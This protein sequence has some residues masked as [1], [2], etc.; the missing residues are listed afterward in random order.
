M[1]DNARILCELFLPAAGAEGSNGSTQTVKIQGQ[2]GL[3]NGPFAEEKKKKNIS[4]QFR[5][6]L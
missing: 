5:K 3:T 1:E 4:V 2:F 6:N